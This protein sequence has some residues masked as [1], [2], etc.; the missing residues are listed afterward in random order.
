MF[1]DGNL[2]GLAE[3]RRP[4]RRAERTWP[5]IFAPESSYVY[6]PD[7]AIPSAAVRPRKHDSGNIRRDARLRVG[8]RRPE[9]TGLVP[10]SIIPGEGASTR[11]GRDIDKHT[12]V[13][14]GCKPGGRGA[15]CVADTVYYGGGLT[16]QT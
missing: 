12:S 5:L 3:S 9:F 6:R 1:R 7:V 14:R 4:R 2:Y 8:A 15:R 10:R 13:L 11:T 16:G